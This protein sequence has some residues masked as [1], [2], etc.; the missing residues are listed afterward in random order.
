[1]WPF[2]LPQLDC[3]HVALAPPL[4]HKRPLSPLLADAVTADFHGRPPPEPVPDEQLAQLPCFPYKAAK[5]RACPSSPGHCA[6]PPGV[7][8]RVA[9]SHAV[10]ATPALAWPEHPDWIA[11][12]GSWQQC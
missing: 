4:S 10:A 9:L 8:W 6:F 11:G 7:Q 12:Q 1:M 2:C 3:T 5:V